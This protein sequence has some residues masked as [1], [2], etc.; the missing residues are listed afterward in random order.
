M[1]VNG[2]FS[3]A[4]SSNVAA[5]L[6]YLL[7]FHSL[8]AVL[9]TALLKRLAFP[10]VVLIRNKRGCKTQ[11]GQAGTATVLSF[12][13]SPLRFSFSPLHCTELHGLRFI[14]LTFTH[15]SSASHFC[16]P[17]LSS[18]SWVHC[19]SHVSI[20]HPRFFF[21]YYYY[22]IS[23]THGYPVDFDPQI[24]ASRDHSLSRL[25]EVTETSVFSFLCAWEREAGERAQDAISGEWEM[26]EPVIQYF[27]LWDFWL[28]CVQP[29]CDMCDMN[30][31]SLL[32]LL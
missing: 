18:S 20:A 16:F 26:T 15:P 4:F 13:R 12:C 23:D 8:W 11:R 28:V 5:S 9:G 2:G 3:D 17:F 27:P 7:S 14:F 22:Y 25:G 31:I 24:S 29:L 32:S 10:C 6:P 19:G 1:S 21:F 30:L